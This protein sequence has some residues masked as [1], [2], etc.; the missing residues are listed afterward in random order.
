[1]TGTVRRSE[2]RRG[3]QVRRSEFSGRTVSGWGH[4]RWRCSRPSWAR[5]P[6]PT[7]LRSELPQI[8]RASSARLHLR[9]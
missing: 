9:A 7:S 2:L 1:L 8:V 5:F 4:V 6:M 3:R